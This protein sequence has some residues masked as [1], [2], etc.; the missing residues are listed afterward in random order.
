M[1]FWI[2]LGFAILWAFQ[3]QLLLQILITRIGLMMPV[4]SQV[5]RLKWTVFIIVLI[6]NI[7]VF[8][9]WIPA[10]LQISHRWQDTNKIWNRIQKVIISI[11]DILLNISF[12]YM[13]RT[14]LIENG[15]TKYNLLFRVN[16]CTV[17]IS[18]A[19]DVILLGLMSIP[20]KLVYQQFQSIGY[21]T[22][23]N[24]EM[25][26]GDMIR[27]VVLASNIQYGS[28]QPSNMQSGMSHSITPAFP[29]R[30]RQRGF[31]QL[32]TNWALEESDLA[33]STIDGREM[34]VELE[35]GNGMG[36]MQPMSPLR[37]AR[38]GSI[39]KIPHKQ[40]QQMSE[41]N[42][43]DTVSSVQSIR[44]R[45]PRYRGQPRSLS[46]DNGLLYNPEYSRDNAF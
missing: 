8:V 36:A 27:K 20:S 37:F 9:V 29:E 35:E 39:D 42:T 34:D 26:I 1:S 28:D 45:F 46:F 11:I 43:A 3:I 18:I 32:S 31:S 40:L 7:S 5:T 19:L 14:R 22:K 4:R 12:I 16:I 25:N 21:L 44:T 13:M 23:L 41:K 17:M 2:L 10:N 15:L 33:H 24:I 6:I 30:N 38:R